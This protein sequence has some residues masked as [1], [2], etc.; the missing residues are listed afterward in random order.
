ML[1]LVIFSACCMAGVAFLVRFF[2][3][4]SKKP[5][6]ERRGYVLDVSQRSWRAERVRNPDGTR[7]FDNNGRSW[8]LILT[9]SPEQSQH[10][11]LRVQ[12]RAE[13]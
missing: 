9:R 11:P 6:P 2:I 12:R 7:W 3:A 8:S 5:E 1:A 4:I 10:R 13:R